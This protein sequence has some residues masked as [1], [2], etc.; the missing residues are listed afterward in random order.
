MNLYYTPPSDSIFEEVQFKAMKLW[1]DI[2]TDN[3]KYGYATEKI[4]RIKDMQNVEDNMMYIVAMFDI[5][6]QAKLADRLTGDARAEIRARLI[7]GGSLLEY[8]VF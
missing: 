8:I 2:D 6:N 5:H 1:K 7:A 4:N 3:D